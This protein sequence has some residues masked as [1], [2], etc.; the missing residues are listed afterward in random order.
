M[1]KI[2]EKIKELETKKLEIEQRL[3]DYYHRAKKGL[4]KGKHKLED[5]IIDNP[6]KSVLVA[7]GIG[8][9]IGKMMEKSK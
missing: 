3:D 6:I 7:A 8:F 2:D 1:P 4:I 9:I 5:K